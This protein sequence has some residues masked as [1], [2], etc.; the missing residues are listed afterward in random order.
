MSTDPSHSDFCRIG[1]QGL[2]LT[3]AS[4]AASPHHLVG[5]LHWRPCCVN[6]GAVLPPLLRAQVPFSEAKIN[7]PVSWCFFS[8]SKERQLCCFL[9]VYAC[10]RIYVCHIERRKDELSKRNIMNI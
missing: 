7:L 10:V 9:S 6:V 8:F 3:V 2:P 4:R 1:V 5:L